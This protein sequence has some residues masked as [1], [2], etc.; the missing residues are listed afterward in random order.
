MPR[1]HPRLTE[2]KFLGEGP[3]CALSK[4]LQAI[5]MH[6]ICKR[7]LIETHEKKTALPIRRILPEE[8]DLCFSADIF[9]L[10]T[11]TR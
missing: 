5:L 11:S 3:A 2:S 4:S 6:S 7:S 8:K 9:G 10:T 1:P